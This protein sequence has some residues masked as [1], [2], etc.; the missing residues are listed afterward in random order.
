LNILLQ[1]NM[2][3]NAC[4]LNASIKSTYLL[5]SMVVLLIGGCVGLSHGPGERKADAAAERMHSMSMEVIPKLVGSWKL[6][7]FHSQ[8]SSGQKAYP[9]GRDA[10]GR[11]TYEPDGRMAVQIM[12]P[13]R[14]GFA[15][16]D[17]LVTSEAEVREAFGGYTAYY[18]T[19]S[20][21]PDDRTI[22]HHIEAALLPNWVGT[23]QQ[24]HFEFNGKYLT[25]KGP[26]LLGGVQ[27]FVSLVWERLP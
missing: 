22:I 19:Y 12:N 15:S 25:L 11:I 13:S 21:N 24:R 10:R 18:G 26:L 17:P 8:D 16:D 4:P 14:P 5:I 6:I 27:G 2:K 9:F 23:D 3:T 7:S 1:G 20:V